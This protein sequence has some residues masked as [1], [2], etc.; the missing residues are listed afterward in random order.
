MT[1][2]QILHMI[3]LTELEQT[4]DVAAY[5]SLFSAEAEDKLYD[6]KRVCFYLKLS[7]QVYVTDMLI[8][9]VSVMIQIKLCFLLTEMCR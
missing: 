5:V 4:L 3:S 8:F 2:S 7:Q 6:T 9:Y 1:V